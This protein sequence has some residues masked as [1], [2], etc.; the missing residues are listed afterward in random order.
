MVIYPENFQL[1]D[2][3]Y[4]NSNDFK[5]MNFY[6]LFLI[7]NLKKELKKILID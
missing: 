5:W 3:K 4:L 1:I 7:F 2:K 6:L